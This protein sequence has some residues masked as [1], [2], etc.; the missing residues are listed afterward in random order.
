MMTKDEHTYMY[1]R[2][3]QT[4]YPL[5]NFVVP[6]DSKY[7]QNFQIRRPRPEMPIMLLYFRTRNN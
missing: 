7:R 5:H 1:M 2:T 3:G 4:L 6:G